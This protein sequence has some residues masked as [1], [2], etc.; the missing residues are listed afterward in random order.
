MCFL[1]QFDDLGESRI[2]ADLR[3]FEA[4]DPALVDSRPCDIGAYTFFHRHGF[5]GQLGLVN[6]CVP[7]RDHAIDRYPFPRPDDHD[8]PGPDFCG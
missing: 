2:R 7:L 5:A 8:V 4:E 3:G 1:Y 6:L